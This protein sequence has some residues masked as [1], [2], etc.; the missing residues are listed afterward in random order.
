VDGLQ[1]EAQF[2][3]CY[4]E[5]PEL[6][7]KVLSQLRTLAGDTVMALVDKSLKEMIAGKAG[8]KWC[9]GKMVRLGG[10]KHIQELWWQYKVI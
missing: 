1:P 5:E 8:K 6:L 10:M 3:R 4:L 7:K 2:Q 9:Y